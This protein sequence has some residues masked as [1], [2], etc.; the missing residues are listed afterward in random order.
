MNADVRLYSGTIN[1]WPKRKP[2][3]S[4]PWLTYSLCRLYLVPSPSHNITGASNNADKFC[5]EPPCWRHTRCS[6]CPETSDTGSAWWEHHALCVPPRWALRATVCSSSRQMAPPSSPSA[7]TPSCFIQVQTSILDAKYMRT[8]VT[9]QP[10]G[11]ERED[12]NGKWGA[13]RLL[14]YRF[15]SL[16][17]P[18]LVGRQHICNGQ[19]SSE[20]LATVPI[21]KWN[22]S[23]VPLWCWTF[24]LNKRF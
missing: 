12:G 16:P 21:H 22:P 7:W 4:L 24:V 8:W 1:P 9:S 11:R 6:G 14:R 15:P 10:E 19:R 13:R 20:C 18:R 5:R 23:S 3:P 17:A 2:V